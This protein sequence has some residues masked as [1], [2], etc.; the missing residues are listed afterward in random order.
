MKQQWKISTV[1][2]AEGRLHNISKCHLPNSIEN[3]I[4]FAFLV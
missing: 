2:I 4:V 1:V 3:S